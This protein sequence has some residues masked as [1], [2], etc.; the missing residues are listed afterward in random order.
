MSFAQ[1][2]QNKSF[3]QQQP[4]IKNQES[5]FFNGRKFT[6]ASH[7]EGKTVI[8]TGGFSLT[9]IMLIIGIVLW[10]V[11]AA[12]CDPGM[13][14]AGQVLFGISVA[15][16]AIVLTIACC[17]CACGFFAANASGNRHNT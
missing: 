2:V 17:A 5:G 16:L 7:T 15:P 1:P 13:V 11:G 12:N 4:S 6:P 14:V 9:S 3:D 8:T 10:A